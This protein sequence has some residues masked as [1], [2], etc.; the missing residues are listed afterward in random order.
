MPG[1]RAPSTLPPPPFQTEVD[2]AGVEW[3]LDA[4]MSVV[5][6]L[7]VLEQLVD[8]VKLTGVAA[9]LANDL[10]ELRDA[11]Y[12]LYCDAADERMRAVI[13]ESSPFTKY[14]K[15]LYASLEAV[16]KAFIAVANGARS[17]SGVNWS[18]VAAHADHLADTS[19][20]D[21]IRAAIT[22]L[23][24]DAKSPIEPLRN[25]SKDVASTFAAARALA[26]R[27]SRFG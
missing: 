14:I 9:E 12:E 1:S 13:T 8:D 3:W 7:S 2:V 11:L 15:G 23:A 18:P 17:G 5:S 21:A 27:L 22:A 20:D 6:S 25:L 10:S 4:H 26:E 16:L 24:I 19:A